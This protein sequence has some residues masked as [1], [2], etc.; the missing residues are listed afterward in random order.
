MCG[1]LCSPHAVVLIP[2]AGQDRLEKFKRSRVSNARQIRLLGLW[3]AGDDSGFQIE[4]LSCF[5][6]EDLTRF[7]VARHL[8]RGLL[9][10]RGLLAGRCVRWDGKLGY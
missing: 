8:A 6:V 9:G 3:G 1:V 10:G 7:R 2:G 5:H 4:Q